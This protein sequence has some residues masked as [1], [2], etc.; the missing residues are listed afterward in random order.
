MRDIALALIIFGSLPFILMRPYIGLLVWSWLGY[1]NPHRLTYGFAYNFP[2]VQIVAIV[3]LIGLF[4]GNERKRFPVSAFAVLLFMFLVWTGFTTFFAAEPAA[5]WDTYSQFAKTLAM[6]LV[7]LVLV[8]NRERMHWLVW[9]IVIS[10]GFYGL[11]GGLYTLLHGGGNHV[12]GPPASFIGDNNDLAM[13]LCMTL[14]LIRYLHLQVQR[15]WERIGLVLLMLLTAV[16]ILG[17]YSRGG[18]IG[19]AAVGAALMIKSRKQLTVILAVLVVAVVAYH[20]MPEQWLARMDTLHHAADTDSAETRVQSWEFAT[21]V[22]LHRP[23][24]GGGFDLYLNNSLWVAYGPN[25]TIRRAIHSI[26]FRVLGEHGFLGLGLFLSLLLASWWNCTVVRRLTRSVVADRWMFDLASMLQVSLLGFM[27]AGAAT[28]SSYFDLTYQ[29]MAMCVILKVLA[30]EAGEEAG[31]RA[32]SMPV[33]SGSRQRPR[34]GVPYGQ[35][36]S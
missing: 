21:N 31:M 5:A 11:K 7:T 26:Y 24:V 35:A 8:H 32:N 12:Y 17:T 19:L 10:L 2:W 4:F 3:T 27:V 25:A 13:A 15:K 14:P 23:L 36:R 33:S 30:K 1:M 20:F 22:A 34:W 9:V 16:S 28:T 29:I 18:L 6:V